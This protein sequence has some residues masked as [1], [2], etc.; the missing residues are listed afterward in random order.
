MTSNIRYATAED[1][2]N[3]Y[4]HIPGTMRCI[5]IEVDGKPISFGGVMRRDGRLV[6]FM[7]MKE[8]AQKYGVSI[9][10]ASVKA[11]KEIISTYSQPVYAIVDDE[12]KSAPAFLKRMG[13]VDSRIADNVKIFRGDKHV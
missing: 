9:M 12:W 11:V 13:F 1:I 5:L 8:G 10:K 6:A 2:R 4:G 7:E 3:W